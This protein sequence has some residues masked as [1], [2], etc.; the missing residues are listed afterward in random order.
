MSTTTTR[1]TLLEPSFVDLIAAIEQAAELSTERRRHWVC[2][3][4]QIAKWLDRPAAVIPARW[5]AVRFSVDQLH[6]ARLGVTAKTVANHKSNLR[7]ALRWFRREEDL[8]QHGLRQVLLPTEPAQRRP[9]IGF[10]V[11]HGLGRHAEAGMMQL[12]DREPDC[13]PA[14]G[15]DRSRAVEPFGDLTQ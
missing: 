10:V 9:E 1:I 7:A 5:P 3:L 12:V 15:D 13:G 11:G 6:H 8:P 2:S 14:G 4:R